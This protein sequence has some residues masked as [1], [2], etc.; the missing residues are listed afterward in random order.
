MSIASLPASYKNTANAMNDLERSVQNEAKQYKSMRNNCTL[1][2]FDSKWTEPEI[3]T[4]S[5][6]PSRINTPYDERFANNLM[7]HSRY[8]PQYD[9]GRNLHLMDL[10][11]KSAVR[12]VKQ[13]IKNI[14]RVVGRF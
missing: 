7:Q 14:L 12:D 1:N 10:L 11:N 9:N 2:F 8:L 5:V 4:V 13:P 6:S 3:D